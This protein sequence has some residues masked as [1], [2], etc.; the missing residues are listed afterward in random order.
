[1]SNPRI[2]IIIPNAPTAP[3]EGA[4]IQE[5]GGE[6]DGSVWRYNG[7]A[8]I[9]IYPRDETDIIKDRLCSIEETLKAL[10]SALANPHD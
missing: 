5:K 4:V 10:I 2:K 1:M 8:W 9:K 3:K 7:K 6:E